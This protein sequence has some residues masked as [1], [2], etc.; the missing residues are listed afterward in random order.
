VKV[1]LDEHL[2]ES[3]AQFLRESGIEV[4][5]VLS[6]DLSGTRDEILIEVCRAE[7]RMLVTLDQ[8][9]ASPLKY[10]PER[11]KG[12][13]ILRP[14]AATTALKRL[15]LETFLIHLKSNP[16]PAGALWIVE[17]GRVRIWKT[18]AP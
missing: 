7:D 16:D 17:I 11:Y 1:K 3:E 2:G 13:V 18:S 4:S 10:P 8:D 9:F 5:T 14:P 6:Q 15:A 12:L